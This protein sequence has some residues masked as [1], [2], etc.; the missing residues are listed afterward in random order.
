MVVIEANCRNCTE[1][2]VYI[3]VPLVL[4]LSYLFYHK[5]DTQIFTSIKT[6]GI[7]C[8]KCKECNFSFI[9]I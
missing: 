2:Y 9:L 6:Y 5:T 8:Q 4:Y 1:G 3:S 7:S